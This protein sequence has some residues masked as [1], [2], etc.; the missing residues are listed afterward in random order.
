MWLHMECCC[1]FL[2]TTKATCFYFLRLGP[3]YFELRRSTVTY[4]T[5]EMNG[6]NVKQQI[7]SQRGLCQ[8]G[9]GSV[10]LFSAGL[11]IH[12]HMDL[13]KQTYRGLFAHAYSVVAFWVT[14]CAHVSNFSAIVI[15]VCPFQLFF[16][17]CRETL[18]AGVIPGSVTLIQIQLD[19]KDPPKYW[20]CIY[21]PLQRGSASRATSDSPQNPTRFEQEPGAGFLTSVRATFLCRHETTLGKYSAVPQG[22]SS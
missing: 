20:I 16:H 11:F 18:S 6:M 14:H 15:S 10:V 12:V 8:P 17:R 4:L 22:F 21:F 2:P 9:T 13:S 5:Y 1:S 3:C 19:F 7:A